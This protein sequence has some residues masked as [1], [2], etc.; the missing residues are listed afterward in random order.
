MRRST[1][2]VAG[3]AA[4]A[5]VLGGAGPASAAVPTAD[6]GPSVIAKVGTVAQLHGTASDADGDPLQIRWLRSTFNGGSLASC[7]FSGPTGFE[8]ISPAG[9]EPTLSCTQPGDYLMQLVAADGTSSFD[10]TGAVVTFTPNH[11]PVVDSGPSVMV[12]AGTDA[13]LSGSA[14][15]PD[16]DAL[17][18]RW[19]RSV[20]AGGN[21]ASCTFSGPTAF[22]PISA[23]GLAPT[24]NCTQPGDYL[25][26]LVAGDGELA[27]DDIGALV[28]FTAPL[29]LT[30]AVC[31]MVRLGPGSYAVRVADPE[32]GV[33]SYRTRSIVNLR[34]SPGAASFATPVASVDLSVR[35]PLSRRPGAALIRHTNGAGAIGTCLVV[36]SRTGAVRVTAIP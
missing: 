20:V 1:V 30:A 6:S 18:I 3:L 24:L 10:S 15:D 2:L 17:E 32:S 12:A 35:R 7:T 19:L 4:V 14:S 5:T 28:T 31:R 34:L 11:A 13:H 25:L 29:D 26:Q 16:G 22:E 33:S 36:V 23:G 9:L 21:L 27:S 8:P